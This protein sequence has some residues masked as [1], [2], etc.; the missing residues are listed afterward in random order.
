[1]P[2][3]TPELLGVE[4]YG[5]IHVPSLIAHG[6]YSKRERSIT[7]VDSHKNSALSSVCVI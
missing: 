6:V 7:V 5:A 2:Q 4:R 3:L 1:M